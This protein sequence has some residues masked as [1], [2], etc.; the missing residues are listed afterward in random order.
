[1][2]DVEVPISGTVIVE[3]ANVYAIETERNDYVTCSCR[4]GSHTEYA[5]THNVSPGVV[6]HI[7]GV[8]T[9]KMVWLP[10]AVSGR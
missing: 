8:K 7:V 1:M 10:Q 9:V 5:R 4:D 6:P 3:D 2:Q